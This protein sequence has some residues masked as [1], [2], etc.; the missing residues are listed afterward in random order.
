VD[1]TNTQNAALVFNL[2]SASST[3]VVVHNFSFWIDFEGSPTFSNTQTYGNVDAYNG[4]TMQDTWNFANTPLSTGT[5]MPVSGSFATPALTTSLRF[6]FL[7]PFVQSCTTSPCWQ[8][9]VYI[10]DLHID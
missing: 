3:G 2:C 4:E 1:G 7:A 8:G 9:W 6:W 10:D 5:Y